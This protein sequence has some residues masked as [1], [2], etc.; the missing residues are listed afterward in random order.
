MNFYLQNIVDSIESEQTTADWTGF[1][2]IQFSQHKKL[3]DFQQE[4]LANAIKALWMYF[5]DKEGNIEGVYELYLNS[6]M[7]EIESHLYF[8][9]RRQDS[10]AVKILQEYFPVSDGKISFKHFVNRMCFWMATGSGKSL[11]I[12]KLIE[13][14]NKLIKTGKL[15]NKDILFLTYRD[16]LIDQ[17]VKHVDEFNRYNTETKIIL[18]S[19]KEYDRVKNE[20]RLGFFS[21]EITVFYYRSDLISDVRSEKYVDFKDY[22]KEGDWYLFLD[23]AHKG[24]REESKRQCYYSIM[25]RNGFMFNFSATF[26]DIRDFTTCVFEYNLA[27]FIENGYG[28]HIYISEENLY[29]LRDEES[30]FSEYDKQKIFI[31]SVILLT[32]IYKHYES[33]KNEAAKMYH[34]PLMVNLVNTVNIEDSDL[35]MVFSEI[36]KI[37]KGKLKSNIFN[38]AKSELKNEYKDVEYE[39]KESRFEINEKDIDSIKT[40]DVLKYV[41]NSDSTG[42]IEVLKIPGNDKELIFKLKTADRPF[43]LSK[44]GDIYTLLKKHFN[45]Y[46]I[47]ESYDNESEFN[48]INDDDSD[49]NILLG[50]RAFYEGWDSNRPN[51]IMFVNIGIGTDT[52]KF[53]LQSIGRG[54]RIEPFKDQRKRIDK[55]YLCDEK[56][57]IVSKIK[58]SINPIETL[59]IY[60]TKAEN[61]KQIIATL[62]EESKQVVIGNEFIINKETED[63][64]LLI[65]VIKDSDE[66]LIDKK[67]LK[68]EITDDD[69]ISTKNYWEYIGDKISLMKYN[70]EPAVLEKASNGLGLKKNDYF[71]SGGRTLG[72]PDITIKRIFNFIGFKNKDVEGFKE[73]KDEIIH[74]KRVKVDEDKKDVVLKK[75]TQILEYKDKQNAIYKAKKEFDADKDLDTYTGLIQD[76]EERFKPES[77]FRNLKFKYLLNHYYLPVVLSDEEKVKYITHIIKVKSEVKF[78]EDLDNYI[79]SN[80]SIFKEYDWWLFSKID[81]TTDKISFPYY[82]PKLNRPVPYYSDF[83]FWLKKDKD[84]KIIFVDPKGATFTDY[85]YKIDGYKMLFEGKNFKHNNSAIIEVKLMMRTINLNLISEGYEKYWF[86]DISDLEKI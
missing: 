51:I 35:K 7:S 66:Y 59:F 24:D 1:D 62:R 67:D 55:E 44:T 61:L 48:R 56:A 12:I 86:N 37:G 84:Y 23:E 31:K 52:K 30:D 68:Y 64:I 6:G 47:N 69:Y 2:L 34:K 40:I 71:Q 53:V 32:Y 20:K 63:K 83:I 38:E 11:V 29:T 58:K 4:A 16:D 41:F 72:K 33:V 79:K 36:E 78:I 42:G 9:G 25:S 15:E 85:Q 26:I 5:E 73:L 43:F 81:H 46:E 8:G 77:S 82:N 49:I 14:L 13:I 76:I 28:K 50:S 54:V 27:T 45:E 65:P 21:N 74:F 19:L 57:K 60:G 18:K 75:I 80:K 10:K 70:I 22:G 17:F 3:Y 39:Y